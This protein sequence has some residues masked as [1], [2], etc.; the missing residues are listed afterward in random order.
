MTDKLQKIKRI[1]KCK[2]QRLKE[3]EHKIGENEEKLRNDHNHLPTNQQIFRSDHRKIRNPCIP[4]LIPFFPHTNNLLNT[5][6]NHYQSWLS[7]ISK[8][9]IFVTKI[10]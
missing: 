8:E 9:L 10:N 7:S 5:Q 2:S 4:S 1:L 3:I 6:L